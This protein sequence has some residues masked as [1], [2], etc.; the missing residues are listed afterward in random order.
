MVRSIKLSVLPRYQYPLE[1]HTRENSLE[2]LRC[3][4]LAEEAIEA[5]SARGWPVTG[6][7][8]EPIQVC[9]MQSTRLS[10]MEPYCT[11]DPSPP[12]QAEGG[13]HHGSN[14][15]FQG[16]QELC[17]R[18]DIVYLMDEVQPGGHYCCDP[19]V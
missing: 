14:Q 12:L 10:A 4:A 8:V 18:R 9:H 5:S 11:V 16:L 6:V 1:S 15:W 7:I 2:D 13:D 19:G 3:L 17:L